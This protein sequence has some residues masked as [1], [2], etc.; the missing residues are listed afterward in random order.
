M[1]LKNSLTTKLL[2]IF[3]LTLTSTVKSQIQHQTSIDSTKLE[4]P[5]TMSTL[6]IANEIFSEHKNFL[7]IIDENKITMSIQESQLSN[8]NVQL[9]NALKQNALVEEQKLNLQKQKTTMTWI[10]A[11]STSIAIV[12]A[13]SSL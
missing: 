8:V 6:R 7:K 4:V 12:F 1:K 10:A 2:L 5:V 11:I 9:A 3:M 13:A